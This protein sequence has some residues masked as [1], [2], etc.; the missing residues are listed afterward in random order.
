MMESIKSSLN[1]D[2]QL[3][4][5]Q[6]GFQEKN[7][8]PTNNHSWLQ[9]LIDR[10]TIGH[11]IAIG[12]GITI[13]VA[14]MGIT[15]GLMVGDIYWKKPALK[16]KEL[17]HE[18]FGLLIE[19]K[20]SMLEA[21]SQFIPYIKNIQLLE[22]YSDYL[23]VHTDNITASLSELDAATKEG[24]KELNRE[25]LQTLEQFVDKHKN[26]IQAYREK[27]VATLNKLNVDDSQTKKIDATT[28]REIL[29][30]FL[31]SAEA[32]QLEKGLQELNKLITIAH[33]NERAADKKLNMAMQLQT[34]IAKYSIVFSVAIA[35]L[36]AFLT[37]WLITRPLMAVTKVT[38]KITHESNF[39]L[40][41][42]VTTKD[43]VG[44][45]ATSFNQ[46]V[47]KVSNYTHELEVARQTLEQ[48]VEERTQELSQALQSLQQTQSQ[49]IQTEKMSSLGQMVAGVAHEI[50]NPVNFI[51]GN[52]KHINGYVDDLLGLVKLYQEEYIDGTPEIQEE[53]E[54]IDLE[55]INEDLP[56]TLSSMRIGAQRIRDIV[57]SL[58]N[59]SRLDEAEVKPINI[60]EGIE[61]TLLLL[62]HQIKQGI[63]IVKEYGDLPLVKCYPAQL[64]QVFM[65]ILNN[66]MDALLEQPE[67]VSKQIII[68]TALMKT[69]ARESVHIM[70]KDNGLGIPLDI[71]EKLFDPFF[72][73]KPIGKGTGLGLSI[74]YKIIEKHQ[75]QIKLI[76]EPGKGAEFII[77]LPVSHDK[78]ITNEYQISTL[79]S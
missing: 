79:I 56:K 2:N 73:T 44:L 19:L 54:N 66:G 3:N 60:H 35:I 63:E 9:K 64:N 55:F 25:K 43:E 46:M 15:I 68:R 45:L 47:R 1:Q 50:N 27:L 38:Q 20:D 77:V 13:G 5:F 53:I 71:Q 67:E 17:T 37:T 4:D 78:N 69:E 57:L 76:S 8:S 10:A 33:D 49:L 51:Y 16:Q 65:N 29:L 21:Q 41:V 39:D 23:L 52:I 59:F 32:L 18:E 74:C 26:T 30:D 36:L 24:L 34:D 62:N 70:I 40:Q 42:P 6:F 31:G 75:G 22:N 48:R 72:T 14:A 12:Y 7:I 28:A 58:R 11:K 61:S